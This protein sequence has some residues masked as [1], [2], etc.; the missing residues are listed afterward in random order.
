MLQI[1]TLASEVLQRDCFAREKSSEN[2]YHNPRQCRIHVLQNK[3]LANR[4]I[5][6][7]WRIPLSAEFF[8]SGGIRSERSLLQPFVY[9]STEDRIHTQRKNAM[10]DSC[11]KN[12]LGVMFVLHYFKCVENIEQ[13]LLQ[14]IKKKVSFGGSIFVWWRFVP[15]QAWEQD[16]MLALIFQREKEGFIRRDSA[17]ATLCRD[18]RPSR[19]K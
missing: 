12:V 14:C 4:P 7:H 13:N 8:I 1:K 2:M 5:T 16:R 11:V 18:P 17:E 19:L 9:L 10:A 6:R 15:L 3:T